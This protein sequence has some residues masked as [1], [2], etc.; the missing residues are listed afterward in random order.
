MG[1]IF[2]IISFFPPNAPIGKPPPIIFPIHDMS[3]FTF[4]Y[5]SA[6]PS[7]ALK[8]V[9]TSSKI[10]TIRFSSQIFLISC[11]K[12]SFGSTS[13]IFAGM[14]SII[15]AAISSLLSSIIFFT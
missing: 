13:P 10:K 5:C 12:L 2:S 7:D 3:G 1:D 6:P 4:K 15:I 8:P 11:I 9:I 14:G